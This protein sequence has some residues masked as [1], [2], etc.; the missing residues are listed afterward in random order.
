MST[1]KKTS[2]EYYIEFLDKLPVSNKAN[3]IF[4]TTLRQNSQ[5][6]CDF[7]AYEKKN[8][9]WEVFFCTEGYLGRAGVVEPSERFEGSGT[10]P[11]GIYSF[12]MLFGLCEEPNGLKKP[13]KQ[14][15]SDDYWDGDCNSDTYNQYVKASQMP[16]EWDRAASEHLI[17]FCPAY[18]YAAMINFN[19]NPA[20]KG[21]GSAIFFHCT[22]PNCDGSA[23]CVCVPEE[24]AI[25]VLQQ[26]DENAYI[27]I[28]KNS[29]DI[30]KYKKGI[31]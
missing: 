25:R 19:V 18:N 24:Y 20:I 14:I 10:T 15:D 5:S 2:S 23:G 4:I 31:L 1:N 30:E 16:E 21:K 29:K 11:A 22:R 27:I 28:L 9:K 13:Y 3:T 8:D 26:I 7:Y 12:G 6:C 17:D